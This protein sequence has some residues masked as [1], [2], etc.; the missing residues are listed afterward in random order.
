[1]FH[2]DGS[3]TFLDVA[4]D[5]RV[6]SLAGA[7][8]EIF[9]AAFTVSIDTPFF[10]SFSFRGDGFV[11]VAHGSGGG[12]S[13]LRFATYPTGSS[14]RV[15]IVADLE[16]QTWSFRIDD[17]LLFSGSF[18]GSS[19]ESVRFNLRD[20]EGGGVASV[21]LD[22]VQIVPEPSTSA[23]LSILGIAVAWPPARRSMRI[24]A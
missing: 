3:S 4:Y 11:D 12:S 20:Y 21:A 5:L 10:H 13:A 14:F 9:G 6:D 16:S 18:F 8:G 15:H 1:M 17:A 7:G 22:D 19:F 23:F 2:L 24:A